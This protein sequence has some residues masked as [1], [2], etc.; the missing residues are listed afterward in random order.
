MEI[1]KNILVKYLYL[2]I[3]QQEEFACCKKNNIKK[4]GDVKIEN[5]IENYNNKTTG[6]NSFNNTITKNKDDVNN[7]SKNITEKQNQNNQ[8]N[9]NKP[10]KSNLKNNNSSHKVSHHFH[11]KSKSLKRVTTAITTNV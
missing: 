7:E 10:I 1:I 3:K 5:S 11:P 6:F 4:E 8:T 9:Q 2:I